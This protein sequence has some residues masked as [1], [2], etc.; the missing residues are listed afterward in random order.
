MVTK[1]I[2]NITSLSLIKKKKMR[3]VS[4]IGKIFIYILLLN[5]AFVFLYPFLYMVVNSLKSSADLMNSAINW[6]PSE[7]KFINYNIAWSALNYPSSFINSLAITVLSTLG[8]LFSGSFIA[9]GFARTNAPFR[10]ALF[11]LLI[12]SIIV[13][14]QVIV[15]SLYNQ[16][17]TFGW[18]NTFY[19]IIVPTYFGFGLNGGIF[20]FI[21]RQFFLTLPKELEDAAYIDGCGIYKTFFRIILPI[22][23]SSLLVCGIISM[24]WHWNDFYEP[25]VYLGKS[26]LWPLTTILPQLFESS[27]TVFMDIERLASGRAVTEAVVLAGIVIA[28]LPIFITYMFLQ[29]YFMTGIERTGI[30]E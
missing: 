22:S 8:H 21:F 9:Y 10:K 14:P 15:I 16:Y 30:V 18:I 29:K 26:E 24:V 25:V 20:V 13:P 4:N 7:L 6:V 2:E 11:A 12:I 5:I 1:S 23:L 3:I 17:G 19:P 28:Q 27:K